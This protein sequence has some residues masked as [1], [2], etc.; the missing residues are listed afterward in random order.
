ML[1]RRNL[2]LG[3]SALPSVAHAAGVI[4]A[5]APTLRQASGRPLWQPVTNRNST[6]GSQGTAPTAYPQTLT[7]VTKTVQTDCSELRTVLMGF[8]MNPY[9]QPLIGNNAGVTGAYAVS[10]ATVAAAG[11]GYTVGDVLTFAIGTADLAAA[12]VIVVRLGTSGAIA[13]VRVA[14]AGAY[15]APLVDATAP[16]TATKRGGGTSA[17]SAA[18]FN[19][20]WGEY[21]MAANLGIE[22]TANQAGTNAA[23]IIKAGVGLRYDGLSPQTTLLV[24]DG[25]YLTTDPIR[26]SLPRGSA[27]AERIGTIGAPPGVQRST[28]GVDY[29]ASAATARTNPGAFTGTLAAGTGTATMGTLTLGQ[30]SA[31]APWFCI[32]G[33]S[34]DFGIVGGGGTTPDT[35]DSAQN[36]GW[37]E[38]GLQLAGGYGLL[39]ITRSG[40]A[41]GSWYLTQNRRFMRLAMLSK[42][43]EIVNFG[44]C[45]F[46]AG[47]CVNDVTAGTTTANIEAMIQ[48]LSQDL[49]AFN[50]AGLFYSTCMPGAVTST[51]SFATVA[52]QSVSAS[53][54]TTRK[55]VN[56]WLRA[57]GGGLFNGQS[58]RTR[59]GLLDRAALVE[60]NNGGLGVWNAAMTSDGTHPTQ[61]THAGV[62]ASLVQTS[63]TGFSMPS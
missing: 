45:V 2:V 26:L 18:T 39:S 5:P 28:M 27:I 50:P 63:F 34:I 29:F 11:T 8:Q 59:T 41:L 19:F 9:E 20:G 48:W 21:A 46:I 51:D 62:M 42:L 1:N 55:A 35:G 61:A 7:R 49:L 57:G 58:G 4:P 30:P 14:D 33:D 22:P 16:G 12:V 40:D 43:S 24:P 54:D 47:L 13:E 60:A 32:V 36:S 44:S 10:A 31:P 38:R 52:N 56:T 37:I 15:A 25:S 17:G 23:A 53:Y 6:N 3:L